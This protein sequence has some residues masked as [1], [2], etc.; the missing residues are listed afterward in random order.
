MIRSQMA[1][2]PMPQTSSALPGATPTGHTAPCSLQLHDPVLMSLEEA[3]QGLDWP[4]AAGM[5]EAKSTAPAPCHSLSKDVCLG[6][7]PG[8]GVPAQNCAPL[9][10]ESTPSDDSD[11]SHPDV[12][13]VTDVLRSLS[14]PFA[15]HSDSGGGWACATTHTGHMSPL[16]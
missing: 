8:A 5:L 1:A 10:S 15:S 7:P 2:V 6:L 16:C 13:R 3:L 9:G 4:R 14:C 12:S 11:T